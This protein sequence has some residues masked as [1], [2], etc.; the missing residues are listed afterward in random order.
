MPAAT[1]PGPVTMRRHLRVL[2]SFL[3]AALAAGAD[4]EP[5]QPNTILENAGR[6][7]QHKCN[8]DVAEQPVHALLD[9][10]LLGGGGAR[11]GGGGA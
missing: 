11:G 7:C 1:R 2:P 5:I 9:G 8:I 6:S 4:P 3:A 10:A